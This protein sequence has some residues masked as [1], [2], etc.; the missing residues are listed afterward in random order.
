MR[1]G[2][3]ARAR[4]KLPDDLASGENERSFEQLQPV[5]FWQRVVCVEPFCE[6]AMRLAQR[7]DPFRVLDRGVHF[8][9]VANDS[10]VGEEANAVALG[11][12]RDAIHVERAV[13]LSE[14]LSFFLDREPGKAGLID[15]QHEPLEQCVVGAEREPV[16]VVVIGSVVRMAFRRLTIGQV[17]PSTGYSCRM[18]GAMC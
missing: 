10:F 12:A 7:A 16:L 4:E 3:V 2:Q 14:S 1:T 18:R 6:R 9:A 15:L 13:S 17:R 11:E 5:R 8:Q